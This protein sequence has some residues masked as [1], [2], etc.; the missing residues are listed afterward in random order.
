MDWQQAYASKRTTSDEAVLRIPKGRPILIASG[1]AEPLGLVE[2]LG[3]NASHFS[4]NQVVHL[5]TL[6][7]AP[8]VRPE[9]TENF[10]HN[11][12]FIGS[13]VR[14]AVHQGRADYTPVFLSQIP[15]LIRARRMPVDVAL[16]QC[17]PPDKFGYVNIGVSVDIM[18]AAIEASRLVIAE[19]NPN[20]PCVYGAGFLKMD[21][22]D[23]WTWN[24]APLIEHLPEEPGEVELEIGRN[25]ASLIEDGS[26][27]QAGIGMIPDAVLRALTDKRD[28]GVWTEMF[29]D[30]VLDLIDA[31]VITGR[32]KTIHPGKVTSSFTFG[33]RR[34]Y[35]YIDRNP[36]FTFQPTD[37]VNDPRRIAEQHKMVAINSAI[38]VD[39]T[40][41]VCADSIGTRFYS[42]IGGQ[43]DFIRGASMCP[44][45][46]PVIA[47]RSTAKGGSI[48]RIVPTL[49]EGAGVV[50][51]RGD[52]RYVV[53]EYGVADLL[54]KSIRERAVALISIAHPDF[55]A[56]LVR[57]AK[58][59]HYVFVDQIEPR[60]RY[61]REV[62]R[63]VTVK[64]GETLL[65]RPIRPTD[66]PKL[67]G[68]FYSMSEDALYKR[69][70][71]VVKRVAHEERQYF[72]DVDYVDNMAIVLETSDPRYEPE[73]VGI[74][75]Y[76][77]DPD[78]DF[79]DVGFI[80]KDT[81]QGK[82]LGRIL[83]EEMIRLARV[84][85]I[86]GLTA[87]VLANNQAMLHLFEQTGL[88]VRTETESGVVLVEIHFE[89][90]AVTT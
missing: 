69:F 78:T 65:L 2:A 4:D 87:D 86:K 21:R 12:F 37:Y 42:G 30:G 79:A 22:I 67:V 29:S 55:R 75:Q 36:L 44:D 85:G 56:E 73:I 82:G 18:M 76:F 24:D 10:R 20:V 13:N 45:G 1:A 41:Q 11:A 54:G 15:Q 7:P 83:V 46:K 43:V 53:T 48:S 90:S 57:D 61:P 51:S 40:G 47:L 74:A 14:G 19:V 77:R 72:L 80:V 27:L 3:R 71:R 66:E 33:S 50:T 58:A 25:V 64:G 52:V 23:W 59:R 62:E 81:W 8:Y 89:E 17:T 16:I 84:N 68:L 63:R 26:T 28:L 39:L 49:T 34:L 9:L 60:G 88:D 35:D 6:G 31:G 32:Y 38:Q 5:M 70:M